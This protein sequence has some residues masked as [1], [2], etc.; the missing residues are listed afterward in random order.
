MASNTI[1]W[2]PPNLSWVSS[3]QS[4]QPTWFWFR[5]CIC[6]AKFKSP[7]VKFVFF[8]FSIQYLSKMAPFP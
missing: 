2:K 5:C 1:Y 4:Q 7:T 3:F 8:K 6:I